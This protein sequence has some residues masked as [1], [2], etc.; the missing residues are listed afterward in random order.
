MINVVIV[1]DD[2]N[3][4]AGLKNVFVWEELGA[5]LVMTCSNGK[6]ALDYMQSHPVD[7]VI[8]DIKMPVMN[9]L[10]L[11]RNIH[12]QYPNTAMIIISAIAD[13]EYA[14]ETMKYGVSD[15]IVKPITMPKIKTLSDIVVRLS[16][17]KDAKERLNS[18]LHNI[19]F[20][21]NVRNALSVGEKEILQ[22]IIHLDDFYFR[23]G[24]QVIKEYYWRMIDILRNFIKDTG[25]M[26]HDDDEMLKQFNQLEDMQQLRE[27]T[28]KIYADFLDF[29][30]HEKQTS[31]KMLVEQIRHYLD[32][33]YSD[34]NLNVNSIAERFLVNPSYLS[35]LFKNYYSVSL[36]NY[37]ADK[38]LGKAKELLIETAQP[39]Q[40]ITEIVGYED[41]NYFNRVFKN[42]V[43]M[44]PTE[45]RKK[46]KGTV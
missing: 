30:G 24:H 23:A 27:F 34:K 42:N 46:H 12:A 25:S 43:K 3:V 1:D 41:V 10:E 37:L 29:R 36:T 14:R 9:G 39:V 33:N 13:F 35:T 44:T 4:I 15:Y 21:H 19:D 31:K 5:N 20:E 6:E 8:F 7:L 28:M 11:C 16:E 2:I 38:R 17:G 32:N 40:K 18:I 45:Y 26:F 22:E